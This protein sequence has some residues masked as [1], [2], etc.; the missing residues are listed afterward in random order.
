M[1]TGK[2][3][4]SA[5][6]CVL[7]GALILITVT[8]GLRVPFVQ[9]NY[10]ALAVI[11]F[12]VICLAAWR[13]GVWAMRNDGD[14][15]RRLAVAGA[16]LITPWILFS[17]LAGFGRPDQANHA[18]N[19]LRYEVLFLCAIA[20]GSGMLVLREALSVAGERFYSV[21]GFGA[22]ML[23]TPLYLV[24][25][26]ILIEAHY[27]RLAGSTEVFAGIPPLLEMSD[28]LLFFGGVLTYL[29]TAAFAAALQR[30]QWLGRAAG[31]AFVTLSLFAALC[32]VNRG[33]QFPDPRVVF[34]HGYMIPGYVAGIPAIPWI[35]PFLLGAVLLRRAGQ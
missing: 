12:A 13:V 4:R 2:G 33:L 35:M 14:D 32:L 31:R 26:A 1:P 18:E 29:A 10:H 7:Y 22:I 24:W 15:R 21:I 20:I 16:L 5:S 28:I 11:Q 25:A 17:F 19:L 30:M 27:A 3:K 9:N 34:M 8:F 23:A 6:L